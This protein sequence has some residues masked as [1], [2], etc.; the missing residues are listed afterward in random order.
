MAGG[1]DPGNLVPCVL[2]GDVTGHQVLHGPVDLDQVRVVDRAP[3]HPSHLDGSGL[4]T[5]RLVAESEVHPRHVGSHVAHTAGPGHP[6]HGGR[7]VG[8]SGPR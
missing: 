1:H 3:A 7:D 6:Q 4:V 2:P 8:R 5:A